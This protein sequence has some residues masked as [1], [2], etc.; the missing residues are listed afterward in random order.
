MSLVG[1][2]E[3]LGLGEIF[4]IVSLSRKTGILVLNSRGREGTIA[5]RLGQVVSATSTTYQQSLGEVLIQKG[6]IQLAILRK[7]LALQHDGGF[8]ERLGTILI[9]NFGIAQGVIEEVVGEQIQNVVFS[10]F[11]WIDGEF[12]FRGQD[13]IETID[14]TKLD[15]LQFMLDQGINPQFL[16]IERT[17][18]LGENDNPVNIGSENSSFIENAEPGFS[19]I[20]EIS[21]SVAHNKP[22]I[23]VDDDGPTLRVLAEGFIGYGF[24][25]QAMT[26]SEDTLIKVDDL[27]RA[28]ELPTVII[29]LIMPKMDGSGVLG[30]IELMELLH[31]N[32]KDLPIIVISDYQHAEAE[33]RV[34]DL[35][36]AFVLKPRRTELDQPEILQ[37]FIS[38]LLP[39]LKHAAPDESTLTEWQDNFNLGDEL[40]FE[41]GH[42][43]QILAQA[44]PFKNSGLSL[45]KGMLEE[46]NDPDLQGGVMLLVLRFAS[47]FMN[48]AI[49]FVL[50]ENVISGIGQFGI[51]GGKKGG[52]ER[53]RSI[54]FSLE[55]GS[56]FLDP[57]RAARSSTFKPDPT[58]VDAYVFE[59]LGAGIPEE[60][61]IGPICHES[62]VVGFL[63]GDNLPEKK[64]VRDTESL[65]IFLSQ[66]GIVMQ[67]SLF[68]HNKIERVHQ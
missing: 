23:I 20:A 22:L 29:D 59:Q 21:E 38:L 61:F 53:V 33:K 39:I 48:R 56:M 54:H 2:L 32:F 50:E 57:F 15:P 36:Y 28:G 46:L 67:K 37:S 40:R 5:F 17:R 35:G 7:A 47:E 55:S 24:N 19:R 3:D 30:G 41:M 11:A 34:S 44:D 8:R 9:N 16:T 13:Q 12:E 43:E 1:N 63:Y 60:V 49:L 14:G 18:I 62:R 58:P 27:Y 10:L 51:S 25:V 26:R 45:L 64:P 66:A 52:D 6:V 31:N 68:E 4:Q 42:D 65:E